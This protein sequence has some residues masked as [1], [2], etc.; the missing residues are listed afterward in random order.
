MPCLDGVAILE[1]RPAP[2]PEPEGPCYQQTRR[3]CSARHER[4]CRTGRARHRA[5]R[6][7]W[8][9]AEPN[10]PA[11]WV[12]RASWWVCTAARLRETCAGL[13]A[14]A[15]PTRLHAGQR[16]RRASGC[17]CACACTA[18][19]A[20]RQRR[21]WPPDEPSGGGSQPRAPYQVP[22]HALPD[23][24]ATRKPWWTR[25]QI[26]TLP[27]AHSRRERSA[28]WPGWQIRRRCR[29]WVQGRG[30]SSSARPGEQR[31]QCAAG[32]DQPYKSVGRWL[33]EQGELKPEQASWPAIKPG[34]A[35]IRSGSTSCCGATR[36]TSSSGKNR[37]L[38]P[39]SPFKAGRAADAGALHRRRPAG[40]SYG[41]LWTPPPSCFHHAAAPPGDGAGH[42]Q[43][44][45]RRGAPGPNAEAQ[46]GRMLPLRMWVR[47]S[48]NSR[49]G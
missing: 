14:S 4:T 41:T 36:A 24:L 26:D 37:C 21:G 34:R 30:G 49:S 10:C 19:K 44:H 5:N 20:R 22:L 6:A 47:G 9:S 40:D 11:G 2:V 15:P 45:H 3:A 7:R 25:Q 27:A 18:W 38:T 29:C 39:A 17:N 35:P 46:L 42:R 48:M 33:I 28:S 8:V 12:R 16:R 23:D 13:G 32:P 43:R 1:G 31:R